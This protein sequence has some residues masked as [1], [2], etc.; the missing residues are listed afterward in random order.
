MRSLPV[1]LGV[2]DWSVN[3]TFPGHSHSFF[4]GGGGGGGGYKRKFQNKSLRK[5]SFIFRD[6]YRSELGSITYKCN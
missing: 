3:V 6:I 5:G 2:M 4:F 1:P